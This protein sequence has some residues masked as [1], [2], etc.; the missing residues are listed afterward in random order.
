LDR[1][2]YED[3]KVGELMGLLYT[4]DIYAADCIRCSTGAHVL[5]AKINL[6]KKANPRNQ[7][8]Q[9]NWKQAWCH[10]LSH[11]FSIKS[12]A[13]PTQENSPMKQPFQTNSLTEFGLQFLSKKVG[14][15]FSSRFF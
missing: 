15:T 10:F 9:K 1:N 7:L 6:L 5:T 12:V 13:T 11:L 2:W 3:V 14:C 4:A 8:A